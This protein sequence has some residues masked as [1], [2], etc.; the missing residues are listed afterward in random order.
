MRSYRIL[1]P[2]I[3]ILCFCVTLVLIGGA[4]FPGD[5]A[6]I[7][8]HNAQVLRQGFDSAYAGVPAL[9]GATSG[10]HLAFLLLF[11]AISYSD[12]MALFLL[13]MVIAAVYALGLFDAAVNVG[14]SGFEAFLISLGGL[15]VAGSVFQL[16]N[17]MDTGLAMAAVA[18]TI[19]LLTDRERTLW[20]PALCGL[21][22]FVRPELAFLAGGAMLL[23][24]CEPLSNCFK[25]ASILLCVA[26]A[27]PF[28]LWYWIDTGAVIPS[29]M[30]AKTY[31][32]A[33]QH[34]GLTVSNFL[35]AVFAHALPVSFPLFV[36]CFFIRPLS[37]RL[38]L[39]GFVVA[40]LAA[41]IWRFPGGLAHNGGRYLFPF[42]PILLFGVAD[43]LS[44]HRR[45]RTLMYA[46]VATLIAP[47]GLYAQASLFEN[48]LRGFHRSSEL[49]VRWMNTELPGQPTIMVH[50]AGYPSYAGRFSLVDLVGLK[51]PD[52][53]EIHKQTTFPSAG[54]SRGDAVAA[55]AEKFHPGYLV[56]LQ[57]WDVSFG[58][59][60]GL[61]AHGWSAQEVYAGTG[62]GIPAENVY[63]V[64]RLTPP[65]SS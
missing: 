15:V 41:L 13:G 10:V 47:L 26:T 16:L 31:F 65:E 8:L 42:V 58:L 20:L 22:T 43:G 48:G 3:A 44:S 23:L 5:D 12:A 6:Y 54:R 27:T 11:E 18:W 29:T 45:R 2:V 62:D 51:T 50:D 49:V 24:L 7:N 39:G 33:G 36:C 52:A 4:A 35:L 38:L 19:K 63:R 34:A 56:V 17:G 14:C 28:L 53:V 30:G 46:A 59:V 55:I 25:A 64:Y 57:D 21:M 32:F 60:A 40:F 9:V 61:R 1:A 37:L